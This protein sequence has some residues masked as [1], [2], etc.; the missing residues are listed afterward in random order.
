MKEAAYSISPRASD[1]GLP[2]SRVMMTARSSRAAMTSS[3]HL[4][5]TA[6]RACGKSADHPRKAAAAASTARLAS[7]AEIAGTDPIVSPLAGSVTAI[8]VSSALRV[9]RPM[10]SPS[11]KAAA[12]KS[13]GSAKL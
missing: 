2:C 3:N 7:A 11:M 5:S 13:A 10:R 9:L 1:S 8:A 6:E 12:Q 4:R